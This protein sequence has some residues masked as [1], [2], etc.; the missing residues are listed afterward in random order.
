MKIKSLTLTSFGKFK[1]QTFDLSKKINLFYGLNEAG[2][3]TIIHFIEGMIYGFYDPFRKGR[4][5]LDIYDRYLPGDGSYM[6]QM[7]FSFKGK[8]YLVERNF[9]SHTVN[10]YHP[11]TGEDLTDSLPFDSDLKQVSLSKLLKLPYPLFMN[12]I[13]MVQTDLD[14][15]KTA[16]HIL[17]KRLSNLNK[18]KTT[19]FSGEGALK[20]LKDLK[21][22]IGTKGAPTKPYAKALKKKETLTEEKKRLDEY[23]KALKNVQ[24]EQTL[25]DENYEALKPKLASLQK[26]K[27]DYYLKQTAFKIKAIENDLKST[28]PFDLN[29]LMKALETLDEGTFKTDLS[30]IRALKIEANSPLNEPTP[31]IDENTYDEGIKTLSEIETLSKKDH[32]EKITQQIKPLEAEK[33]AL[34]KNNPPVKPTLSIWVILIVPLFIFLFKWMQY[35]KA[36][37]TYIKESAYALKREKA[38]DAS[39]KTLYEALKKEEEI[40]EKNQETIKTLESTLLFNEE[41]AKTKYALKRDETLRYLEAYAKKEAALQKIKDIQENY[42]DV[43]KKLNIDDIDLEV[44]ENLVLLR[45]KTKY[46]LGSFTL[47]KMNPHLEGS[48][49]LQTFDEALLD[50]LKQKEKHYLK[51]QSRLESERLK[52]VDVLKNYEKVIAERD[53]AKAQIIEFEATLEK[54]KKAEKLL[55]RSIDIIEENFAPALSDAINTRLKTVTLKNYQSIKIRRDL[56]FKVETKNGLKPLSYFSTGTLDQIYFAIRLGILDV[57]GLENFPLLLDDAFMHYDHKRLEA[58]LKLVFKLDRQIILLTAHQ[59]EEMT[60]NKMDVSYERIDLNG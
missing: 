39:L 60:L 47:E 30:E 29:T 9:A 22:A 54:I 44:L 31:L 57:L 43:F 32:L 14:T 26:E 34:V 48:L 1:N 8:T 37:Q 50:D 25:T 27:D 36:N 15:K 13:R 17:F 58:M 52:M 7:V 45:N 42:H 51:E 49:E 16:E 21:E 4:Y 59:R 23:V 2:K 28:Y 6:G 18:T 33:E 10:V 3:T 56:T 38:I 12:T 41:D 55:K 20:H 53:E 24:H 11:E 19:T 35:Q 40:F 46:T 5:K